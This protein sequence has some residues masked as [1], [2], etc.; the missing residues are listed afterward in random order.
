MLRRSIFIIIV[1]LGCFG[2]SSESKANFYVWQDEN[3]DYSLSFPDTWDLQTSVNPDSS[4]RISAPIAEDLASC[5]VENFLD[6][7]L[8]IYP[9]K[10]MATAVEQYMGRDFWEDKIARYNDAKISEYYAPSIMGGRGDATAIRF[11]YSLTDKAAKAVGDKRMYGAMIGSIYGGKQFI[12]E[13]RALKQK[14][15]TYSVLFARIMESVQLEQRYHPFA[16]GYYRNFLA[17]PHLS[18]PSSKPGTLEHKGKFTLRSLL[19][20]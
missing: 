19:P 6:G 10:L 18:V 1:L 5:S 7:R 12:V 17:D 9:K 3:G 14:F 2:G 11:S 16:I 13:C 15:D 20:F 4:I 8:K